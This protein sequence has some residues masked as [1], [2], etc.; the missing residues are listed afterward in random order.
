MQSRYRR[1]PPCLLRYHGELLAGLITLAALSLGTVDERR[2]F[3]SSAPGDWPNAAIVAFEQVRLDARSVVRGDIVVAFPE[4]GQRPEQLVQRASDTTLQGS[5]HFGAAG[6]DFPDFPWFELGGREVTVEPGS[7]T[8]LPPGQYGRVRVGADAVVTLTAGIYNLLALHVGSRSR[9]ECAGSCEIRV[10]THASLDAHAYLGPDPASD[11][12]S[13]DV[14]VLVAGVDLSEASGER[15]PS[16]AVE[17]AEGVQL[18]AR[19]Y[20]PNGTLRLGKDAVSMAG[21]IAR[22]VW[23]GQ[24]AQIA[25]TPPGPVDLGPGPP[26]GGERLPIEA[27]DGDVRQFRLEGSQRVRVDELFTRHAAALGLG[28]LDKMVERRVG[29]DADGRS[30]HRY[31]QLH[32]GL[33]VLGAEFVVQEADGWVISGIGRV[34]SSLDLAVVPGLSEEDARTRAVIEAGWPPPSGTSAEGSVASPPVLAIAS[35]GGSMAPE[36]FRLVY[37]IAVRK[38]D[39]RW[40]TIDVDAR[41]GEIVNRFAQARQYTGGGDTLHNGWKPFEVQSFLL[42]GQTRYR[43]VAPDFISGPSSPQVG[44][45]T[46][47]AL[48]LNPPEGAPPPDLGFIYDNYVL[49]HFVDEDG[50]FRS[51]PLGSFAEAYSQ[52]PATLYGVSVHWGLQQAVNY[53]RKAKWNGNA[54]WN[55]VD[56]QGKEH[57]WG[58]VDCAD[59]YG[60]TNAIFLGS[61]LFCFSKQV[62]LKT[63]GHEFGHA[64][65]YHATGGWPYS[66]EAGA[67]DEGFADVFG[68]LLN[69]NTADWCLHSSPATTVYYKDPG[70]AGTC[71]GGPATC[72]GVQCDP[73]GVCSFTIPAVCQPPGRSL[74][75][76]KSTKNPDTFMGQN[77]FTPIGSDCNWCHQDSTI[78]GHWFYILVNGKQ[79]TNDKGNAYNVAGIDLAKAEQIVQRT[80]L[81]K[82]W[83]S[84]TFHGARAAAIQAAEDLFGAG[85]SEV[86]AVTNAWYAVGVGGPYDTRFYKPTKVS[87]VEPWPATLWWEELHGETDWEVQISPSP[88]FDTDTKVLSG[89]RSNAAGPGKVLHGA[90]VGAKVNLRPT[91]TYYWRVR[92]R[93]APPPKKVKPQESSSKHPPW[94][95]PG[96]GWI[97][98]GQGT[99]PGSVM[100]VVPSFAAGLLGDWGPWGD[101]QTFVTGEKVP[102]LTRPAPLPLIDLPGETPADVIAVVM[103]PGLYYPWGTEFRWKGV[104]GATQYRLTVSES[105]NRSCKPASAKSVV[106]GASSAHTVVELVN[107]PK[108]PGPQVSH[109]VPLRSD[110]TYYW[111]LMAVGPDGIPGGCA[112]GGQPVQFRTALP[113]ADLVSPA[114]GS[115]VSPFETT[116]T[117]AAVKGAEA[118][119]YAL[120]WRK[121]GTK[122]SAGE[123]VDSTSTVI[124]PGAV[125]TFF[126]HVR[127]KGPLSGDLGAV[128]STWSFVTDLALTKPELVHPPKEYWQRYGDAT[129]FAWR[130]V[131]G[132][133]GYVLRVYL[134]QPDLTVGKVV[135]ELDAGFTEWTPWPGAP[136]QVVAE[137]GSGVEGVSTNPSG[138]CWKVEAIGPSGMTGAASDVW[139][140]RPGAAEVTILSP[141]EGATGV[142]YAPTVITWSSP[143]SPG[144]YRISF[145]FYSVDTGC[146][147]WTMETVSAGKTALSKNLNPDTR[148]C[149]LA[150]GVNSDGSD[151]NYGA[152]V[153]FRTKAAPPPPAPTCKPLD[154]NAITITWPPNFAP[155]NGPV[156]VWWVE[157]DPSIKQYKVSVGNHGSGTPISWVF[158]SA[159]VSSA[160]LQQPGLSADE[161]VFTLPVVLSGSLS[162]NLLYG[163]LVQARTDQSCNWSNV[164]VVD[165]MWFNW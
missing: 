72:P 121:A 109:T 128:S 107:A 137:G 60:E 94:I 66:G 54:G 157:E 120:Q 27:V 31:A 9:L 127:P 123:T 22:V 45:T 99:P 53:W 55:G 78:V 122:F 126:W 81:S 93:S 14:H 17:V 59:L 132:A 116:L 68:Y 149:V 148:Y 92:A 30:H 147:W 67:L 96:R 79:G 88:E 135:A 152:L 139:C 129:A 150:R 36:S 35:A 124:E 34:V 90:K 165:G 4:P 115:K 104:T 83:S 23:L 91:T 43:L 108:P 95:R 38:R 63:I 87:G 134:R 73:T 145:G 97:A 7:S 46:V 74:S 32:R 16:L 76:P 29:R 163:V 119:G 5:V 10:L 62:D 85:S 102:Q 61:G 114:D 15:A 70:A 130:P 110:R 113:K 51:W 25:R 28:P 52:L 47:L 153:T 161:R 159:P 89:Q 24:G 105:A 112:Y 13:G 138:Y 162:T 40:D 103:A 146:S 136:P 26:S 64:V 71:N 1:I 21:V 98:P 69:P 133:T 41:T 48:G 42:N 142:E 56:G 164:G 84:V 151:G 37:R 156:Q 140:Y 131:A 8:R 58:F 19:L 141:A 18:D 50:D 160:S 86:V 155:L 20:A 111:W 57:I 44:I 154:G 3:A 143:Y 101:T 144:G 100:V 80:V 125:G 77:Y 75:A 11:A 82:V 12:R 106:I 6:V 118:S 39:G 65:I 2:A 158:E 49:L 117:W 33:P